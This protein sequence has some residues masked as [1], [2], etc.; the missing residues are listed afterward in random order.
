MWMRPGPRELAG[1]PAWAALMVPFPGVRERAAAGGEG[2]LRQ[3]VGGVEFEWVGEVWDG[4]GGVVEGFE[5]AVREVG[6]WR[7][8]GPIGEMI[9]EGVVG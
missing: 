8:G 4:K 2:L 9:N 7:V 5:A 1:V 6:R 3:W